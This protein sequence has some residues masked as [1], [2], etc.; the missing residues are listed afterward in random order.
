MIKIKVK[1][2]PYRKYKEKAIEVYKEHGFRRMNEYCVVSTLHLVAMYSLVLESIESE[3]I[4]EA[5]GELIDFY[6][7]EVIE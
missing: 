7:C 3:E 5:L 6:N 4:Q 1:L 2:S